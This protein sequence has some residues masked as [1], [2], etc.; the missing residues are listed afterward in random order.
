M[1]FQ[2]EPHGEVKLVRCLSGAIC[3][4]IIDLRLN[5]PLF[6][7]GA[8]SIYLTTTDASCIFQKALR[9]AFRRYVTTFKSTI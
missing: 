7:S 5:L 1:H 4:V 3:D 2:R 6:V 9:M 8:R